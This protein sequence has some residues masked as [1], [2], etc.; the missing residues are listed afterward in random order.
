[1]VI[2]NK[3]DQFSKKHRKISLDFV[4]DDAFKQFKC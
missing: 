4:Y 1:M 2:F 3:L